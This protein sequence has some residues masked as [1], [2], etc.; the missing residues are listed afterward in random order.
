M[1]DCR[2]NIPVMRSGWAVVDLATRRPVA[3]S[4]GLEKACDR[5]TRWARQEQVEGRLGAYLIVDLFAMELPDELPANNKGP[6]VAAEEPSK[7][8]GE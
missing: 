1:T 4:N 3:F 2:R 5:V 7:P 6:P 8:S